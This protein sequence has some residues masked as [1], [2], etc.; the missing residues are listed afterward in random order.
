MPATN[1]SLLS[2]SVAAA[3]AMT[4]GL[5]YGQDG[6]LAPDAGKM[7]GLATTDGEIADQVTLDVLGTGI[8]I[9]G[10][11]VAKDADLELLNGKL[12]TKA[13]GVVVARALQAAAAD[14][15][16]IEVLLLPS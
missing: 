16:K 9:A 4:E 15:D 14:G 10:G 2:L 13:A 7:F 8:G 12:I 5:A 11:V 1:I 6:N 3:V